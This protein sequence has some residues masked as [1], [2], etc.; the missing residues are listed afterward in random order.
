MAGRF[1]SRPRSVSDPWQ[2]LDDRITAMAAQAHREVAMTRIRQD[3][4][5]ELIFRT[6]RLRVKA[7]NALSL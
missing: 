6:A 2:V 3:R 5:M 1:I 7:L 4:A